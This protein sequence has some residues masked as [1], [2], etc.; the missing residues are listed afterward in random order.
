[1]DVLEYHSVDVNVVFNHYMSSSLGFLTTTNGFLTSL[2]VLTA[3]VSFWKLR[4]FSVPTP[5]TEKSTS[6]AASASQVPPPSAGVATEASSQLSS[7]IDKQVPTV[8][9]YCSSVVSAFGTIIEEEE[10][11]DADMSS[12]TTSPRKFTVMYYGDVGN[13]DDETTLFQYCKDVVHYDENNST[14]TIEASP[15]LRTRKGNNDF[16]WYRHQ[17]LSMLNGNVVKLWDCKKQHKSSRSN[18][19]WNSDVTD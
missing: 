6:A 1:M 14:A 7:N 4:S 11:E 8:T 5:T 19:N 9:N 3:V 16:G 17:D 2:A 15:L 18:I 12:N 10:E 13:G